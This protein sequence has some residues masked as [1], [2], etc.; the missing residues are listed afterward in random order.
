MAQ[1]ITNSR[2]HEGHLINLE[3]LCGQLAHRLVILLIVVSSF[4]MWLT[5]AWDPFPVLLF[6]QLAT[7]LCLGLAG[8]ALMRFH[9]KWTRHLLVWGF[10]A[11]LLAAMWLY[12][13]PWL[14]FLSLLL[15][16]VSAM[17]VSGSELVI[18]CAIAG[19]ALWLAHNE[20]HAYHWS[21]LLV[22]LILGVTVTWL[23]VRTLYTALQWAW[24]MQQRSDHLLVEVRSHRAEVSRTLKSYELANT[25]LRRTERE[26]IAARREAD[27]ARRAKEQ[28]AAN[29]SH[30]LR[31]PLNLILGF[32]EMMYLSPEVYGEMQWPATLRRDVYQVYHNSR[33]LLEMIDDILS[34]S[35]FEMT[36]FILNKEPTALEP[37]LRNTADLAQD[38]FRGQPVQQTVD[39]APDLPILEIDR[40]R[41][42]QVLLNL[43]NNA[44]RFTAQGTVR[45]EAKQGNGEVV[46]SVSDTGPGIP[47]AKLPHIFEE[48]YQVDLSLRRGHEGTGLGLTISKHFVEA[49]DGHIGVESQ[50][51]VGSTFYF[52]LPI[53]EQH[54]PLSHLHRTPAVEQSWPENQ[55]TI[56]IA[57]PDPAVASL[58]RR[59]L[60]EYNVI[61]VAN[62]DQIEE[63]IIAH[64]PRAVIVNVPPDKKFAPG[65]FTSLPVPIIHCSLPSQSWIVEKLSVV[66]C[67]TKPVTAQRLLQTIRQVE[68]VH[69]VLIIDDDRGF[70]QLV[71]RILEA[72]D[73]PFDL[74]HAYGG[75]EGLSIFRDRRPDL[76]L[77]DLIM[78][79]MDGFQVLETM[80]QECELED[81]PVILLTATNYAED[82]IAQRGNRIEIHRPDGLRATEILDCLPK[83]I[84]ALKPHYDGQWDLPALP[85]TPRPGGEAQPT[86]HSG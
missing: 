59:Y 42:R 9:P 31:T 34:L 79:D 76:L 55:A 20:L 14:P 27:E 58:M 6:K 47:A 65:G 80:R 86:H 67:L 13:E 12:S 44:L 78:P 72:A 69:T 46:I 84:G 24:T 77:L 38:L 5:L 35:R 21:G 4:G 26:L 15:I 56:L 43:L 61:P 57:D 71:Q 16:F 32:S 11:E 48:F 60:K 2:S 7:L 3:D 23:A 45:L 19:L 36:G 50:E 10:L 54:I 17:L 22:T 41:I 70:C 66:A 85:A 62:V 40:T 29:I 82:A 83:I 49:H 30:E 33:H 18:T 25:I 64:Y 74:L 53:P 28:F 52:S 81:V 1:A 8:Q 51:G 68:P 63:A 39:I 73:H 75:E 37:L